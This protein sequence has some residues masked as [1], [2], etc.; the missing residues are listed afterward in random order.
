[1][2][3]YLLL[4]LTA[5]ALFARP[6]ESVAKNR[7]K[8]KV[9]NV[10]KKEKN[11]VV[12]VNCSTDFYVGSDVYVLYI[13]SRFF[14]LSEQDISNP[15]KHRIKFFVPLADYNKLK[16]RT[17]MFLTYGYLDDENRKEEKIAALCK[18]NNRK[19]WSLGRLNK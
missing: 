8:M 6:T 5:V 17:P 1:M 2:K 14:D 10:D 19:Y 15:Y 9:H 13:G 3:N 11:V 18:Q 12:T 4:L 16:D 7:I